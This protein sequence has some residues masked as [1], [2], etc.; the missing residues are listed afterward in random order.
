M[1]SKPWVVG[2]IAQASEFT[3]EQWDWLGSRPILHIWHR[4][5]LFVIISSTLPGGNRA[6]V[7]NLC[8]QNHRP[9]KIQPNRRGFECSCG[10][11]SW[12]LPL[13]QEARANPLCVT[14]M[15]QKKVK[16]MITQQ[17]IQLRNLKSPI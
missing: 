3:W 2:R 11:S 13:H 9:V 10:N 8:A 17:I 15:C 14:E 4:C 6:S 1:D 16:R 5:H 12:L 7:T